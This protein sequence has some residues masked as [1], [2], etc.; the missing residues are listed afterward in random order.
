M[1]VACQPPLMHLF[2]VHSVSLC[3][4]LHAH[5]LLRIIQRMLVMANSVAHVPRFL[6]RQQY[7]TDICTVKIAR[8]TS[9]LDDYFALKFSWHHFVDNMLRSRKITVFGR[10]P[11]S[12][13]DLCTWKQLY[14]RICDFNNV[15]QFLADFSCCLI[16]SDSMLLLLA[17]FI[18]LQW[19]PTSK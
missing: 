8:L 19:L 4:F 2:A 13:R 1:A 3:A 10:L 6:V 11:V 12:A 15:L 17:L 5:W 16:S 7:F 9:G 18:V 14:T